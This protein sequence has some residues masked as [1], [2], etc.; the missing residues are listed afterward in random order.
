M[1]KNT[2]TFKEKVQAR[3]VRKDRGSCWIWQGSLHEGRPALNL[4]NVVR[5]IFE[6][7]FG[8]IPEGYT[9]WRVDHGEQCRRG[10]PC[11][12]LLCVNPYHVQLRD[13]SIGLHER[14]NSW[15]IDDPER[16]RW[17]KERERA[18]GQKHDVEGN[19][20]DQPLSGDSG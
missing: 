8:A 7:E 17:Y 13:R 14:E 10:T 4:R 12:H 5:F 6:Q 19:P 9:L 3:Y 11:R 15:G 20:E 2:I 1:P 16:I 18:K